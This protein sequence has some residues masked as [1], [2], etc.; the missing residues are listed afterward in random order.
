MKTQEVFSNRLRKLRKERKMSQKELAQALNL[1]DVSV[2]RYELGTAQPSLETLQTICDLFDVT[3]DY[4][5][6]TTDNLP[7]KTVS[8]ID[9]MEGDNFQNI[10]NL[11]QADNIT[12]DSPS[13]DTFKVA[14][15]NMES[16][17]KQYLNNPRNMINVLLGEL[18]YNEQEEILSHIYHILAAKDVLKKGGFQS[19]NN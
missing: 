7:C 12:E 19:E 15:N 11:K 17:I 18:S 8:L 14:E 9:L 3:S 10:P 1:S 5:I 13:G 6:G 16:A 2:S 4:L